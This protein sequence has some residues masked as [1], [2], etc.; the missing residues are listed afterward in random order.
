SELYKRHGLDLAAYNGAG[1]YEL[2]VPGTFVI[3]SR[4]I[5]R[6]AFADVD[7]KKRME[8]AAIIAALRALPD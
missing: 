2:P 7:Y 6:A 5:V 1:R 4:G 8:P 3:D